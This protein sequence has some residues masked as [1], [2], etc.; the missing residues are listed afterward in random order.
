MLSSNE[1]RLD[2]DISW[3]CEADDEGV[4]ALFGER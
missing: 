1:W 3:K 4:C 2:R